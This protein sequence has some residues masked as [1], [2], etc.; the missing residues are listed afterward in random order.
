M[1]FELGLAVAMAKADPTG[2]QDTW[3]VLE[4]VNRRIHKSLSDLNGTEVYIHGGKASGVFRELN[5][6]FV[7]SERQPTMQQMQSVFENL[8]AMYPD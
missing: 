2:R 1:P 5:N 6:A 8:R 3:F 4:T 7:R